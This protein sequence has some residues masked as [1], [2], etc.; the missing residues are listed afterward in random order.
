NR[1]L[2]YTITVIKLSGVD[3]HHDIRQQGVTITWTYKGDKLVRKCLMVVK[4]YSILYAVT[5]TA[6]YPLIHEVEGEP[7]IICQKKKQ[8]VI[9]DHKLP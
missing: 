9:Y 4:F 2:D 5:K 3:P 7:N 1:G 6:V 8:I